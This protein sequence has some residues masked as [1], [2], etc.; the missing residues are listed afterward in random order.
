MAR[1]GAFRAARSH[2]EHSRPAEQGLGSG[3]G[4]SPTN[5][6]PRRRGPPVRS[7]ASPRARR[8]RSCE[9]C[10]D[11]A[12]GDDDKVPRAFDRGP[13]REPR[14]HLHKAG[15]FRQ[16]WNHRNP[17]GRRHWPR[18]RRWGVGTRYEVRFRVCGAH[19]S[20]RVR[21]VE[22]C[23]DA[24]R[25]GKAGFDADTVAVGFALASQEDC[26]LPRRTGW[27]ADRP[28][29]A[30]ALLREEAREAGGLAKADCRERG[31]PAGGF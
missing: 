13:H 12:R 4:D 30:G 24:E 16:R 1:G 20:G 23:G 5:L 27:R 14:R 22:V 9:R 10:H 19:Q 25:I 17:F 15:Q 3:H 2:L 26:A 28:A 29:C 6:I 8:Q 11:A 21:T 7:A 31:V 18:R